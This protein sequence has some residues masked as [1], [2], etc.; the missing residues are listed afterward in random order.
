MLLKRK[1]KH[2]SKSQEEALQSN[3][4]DSYLFWNEHIS[5]CFAAP[6]RLN[7]YKND[8]ETF[9]EYCEYFEDL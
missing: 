2:L 7:I 1:R 9:T 8:Y 3:K 6:H 4:L 5:H